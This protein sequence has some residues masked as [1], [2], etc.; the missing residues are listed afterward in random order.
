[1]TAK[2]YRLAMEQLTKEHPER[3]VTNEEI[4]ARAE[5]I[6]QQ[7]IDQERYEAAM[8]EQADT[9]N[10]MFRT[11]RRIEPAAARRECDSYAQTEGP[12]TEQATAWVWI[13][14]DTEWFFVE[15]KDGKYYT[16]AFNEDETHDSPAKA[17]EWLK[18]RYSI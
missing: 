17:I 15:G 7:E 5:E 13:D 2:T 18:G 1:M 4:D 8:K 11:I 6:A 9:Q 12:D 16:F 10:R 14:P 3:L